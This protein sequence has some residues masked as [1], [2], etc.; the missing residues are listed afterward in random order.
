MLAKRWHSL[1]SNSNFWPF[2]PIISG[3][4]CIRSPRLWGFPPAHVIGVRRVEFRNC[5]AIDH[6]RGSPPAEPDQ[7]LAAAS[8]RAEVAGKGASFQVPDGVVA[9]AAAVADVAGSP[10]I[11]TARMALRQPQGAAY[12]RLL[13][14]EQCRRPTTDRR[15]CLQDEL[16]VCDSREKGGT[17]CLQAESNPDTLG[18]GAVLE[19]FRTAT[20]TGSGGALY[21]ALIFTARTSHCCR[22]IWGHP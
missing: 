14:V 10:E 4:G 22:R 13:P 1:P 17:G 6:G 5:Q 8:E 3:R 20:Q 16:C 9:A 15:Y 21:P 11:E 7:G 19:G 12:F 2:P 18:A